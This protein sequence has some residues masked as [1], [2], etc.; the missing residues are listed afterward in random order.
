MKQVKLTKVSNGFMIESKDSIEVYES[1]DSLI[2]EWC[3]SLTDILE[4]MKRG[5]SKL[6]GFSFFDVAD[7]A[8]ESKGRDEEN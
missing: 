1:A 3:K 2:N 8:T 7:P 4:S 6:V 5:E